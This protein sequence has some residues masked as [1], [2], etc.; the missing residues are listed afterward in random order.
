LG[1]DPRESTPGF[2]RQV[3]VLNG[4]VRSFNRVSIVMDL[5]WFPRRP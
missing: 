3:T 4:E 1:F 2:K 5:R